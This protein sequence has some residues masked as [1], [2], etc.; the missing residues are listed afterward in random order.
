MRLEPAQ[1]IVSH[2]KELGVQAMAI[3]CDITQEEEVIN[4]AKRTQ[5]NFGKVNLLFNVAG[6]NLVKKFA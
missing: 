3:E 2:L 4:L 1:E 6:V 5:K